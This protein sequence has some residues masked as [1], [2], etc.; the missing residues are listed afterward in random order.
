MPTFTPPLG[1]GEAWGDSSSLDPK[2]RLMRYYGTTSVGETVWKDANGWHQGQYPYQGGAEYRTFDD[3]V[4]V[5]ESSDTTGLESADQYFLGGHTYEISDALATE[6][7]AAGF[8]A[9]I[10]TEVLDYTWFKPEYL[11]KFTRWNMTIVDPSATYN[12]SVDD[13]E[14]L[15]AREEDGPS[16]FSSSNRMFWI[17]GDTNYN[18][19]F[20]ATVTLDPTHYAEEQPGGLFIAEQAGIVLRAQQSGGINKGITINNNIFFLAPIINIGV[21]QSNTDGTG[22]ISRGAGIEAMGFLSFPHC[23]DVKLEGNII[24]VRGYT[25]TTPK[26]SWSDPDFAQTMNL[27]TEAGDAEQSPTPVGEGSAGLIAAHLGFS[28]NCN[29]RYRGWKVGPRGSLFHD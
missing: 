19:D 23:Y 21:W 2:D 10:N 14:N 25:P 16:E 15:V 12:L 27:D 28:P 11:S 24:T 7:I 8:G 4:L 3:G 26:P 13:S 22:F 18:S 6:L 29:A 5:S 17:H 1:V 9:Y 20:D